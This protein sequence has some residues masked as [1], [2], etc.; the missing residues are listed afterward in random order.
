MYLL[1]ISDLIRQFSEYGKKLNFVDF[2]IGGSDLAAANTYTWS[3]TDKT[4]FTYTS[5]AIS[6]PNLTPTYNCIGIVSAASTWYTFSCFNEKPFVCEI[7]FDPIA[8]FPT[9]LTTPK[10]TVSTVATAPPV[11]P[12]PG[13]TSTSKSSPIVGEVTT[14]PPG[15]TTTVGTAVTSPKTQTSSDGSATLEPSQ[16]TTPTPAPQN[17]PIVTVNP[18]VTVPTVSTVPTTT[19]TTTTMKPGA[20][21]KPP[22]YSCGSGW[23]YFEPT[24]S[25]FKNTT[26]KYN[27]NSAENY[28]VSQGA[29]L[30]SIESVAEFAF[31]NCEFEFKFSNP[32][33]LI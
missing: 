3:W 7:P 9:T 16:T 21:T 18:P 8:S 19:P 11:T 6:Q 2:W 30:A 1:K 24:H 31:L 32:I 5:W 12:P 29:K 25:C 28:C 14:L 13:A 15:F 23:V 10:V 22:V 4:P 27:F 17:T 20:S 33:S 26:N